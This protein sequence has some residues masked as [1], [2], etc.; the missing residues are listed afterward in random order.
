MLGLSASKH[1]KHLKIHASAA[2]SRPKRNTSNMATVFLAMLSVNAKPH[3]SY[4]LPNLE[5]NLS[6]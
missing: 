4:R 5:I 2:A 6:R 3:G 1:G